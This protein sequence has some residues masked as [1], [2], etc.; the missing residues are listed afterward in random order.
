MLE[1]FEN[2]ADDEGD[3]ECAGDNDD[4]DAPAKKEGLTSKSRGRNGAT[5]HAKPIGLM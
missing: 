5:K 3:D 2:A 4:D 1:L